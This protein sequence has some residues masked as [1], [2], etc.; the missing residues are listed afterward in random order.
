MLICQQLFSRFNYSNKLMCQK[1]VIMYF[2]RSVGLITLR[3]CEDFDPVTLTII[4]PKTCERY[5][6][7]PFTGN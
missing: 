5:I 3:L 1:W 7:N 6:Y 4:T 2:V